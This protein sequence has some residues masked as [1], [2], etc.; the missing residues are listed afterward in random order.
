MHKDE[1]KKKC[2]RGIDRKKHK[3]QM[4]KWKGQWAGRMR[5]V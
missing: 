1:K 3:E 2:K 4:E 5:L